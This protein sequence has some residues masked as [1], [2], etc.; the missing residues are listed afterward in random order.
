MRV[1]YRGDL[2]GVVCAVIL[3]EV[4]LCDSVKIVHPNDMQEGKVDITGEDIICNLPYHPNCHMWFDHHS[5]EF[6]KSNFP[7]EFNGIVDEAPS[8]AGLVFKYFLPDFG[9]LKKYEEL[10]YETDLIDSAQLTQEQVMN[11][12]GTYLLGFLLDS[13]TGL[14]YHKDFRIKNFDWVNCVIDWLTQ[15]SVPEVLDMPDSVERIAKYREMQD[16]GKRFYR[17]NSI[18]DSNV[19]ITDIRGKIIPPGNRFLIYSLSGLA[20][21][22]IS[23]RLASGKKGEFNMISVA[24]S[25]FVKTSKVHV[26][27]L[28]QQ[29]G[30]GG[31][32]RAGTCQPSIK[33]TERIFKEVIHACKD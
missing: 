11:P 23:V 32:R 31:H 14:G 13:R 27:K 3:K 25:I 5:S 10:V 20:K 19:I 9:E 7:K 24:H 12:E 1:I 4:G 15:Y 17:N 21:G 18:L 22:N 26:G 30:G 29:Y 2:D 8:A 6:D 28:C 16:A 33:D